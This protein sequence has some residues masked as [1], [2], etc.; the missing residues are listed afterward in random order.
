MTDSAWL[1]AGLMLLLGECAALEQRAPV[2]KHEA[3]KV[4]R[5]EP[6][7]EQ[8]FAHKVWQLS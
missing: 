6:F 8:V 4:V 2:S 3:T 7:P 5:S 1:G